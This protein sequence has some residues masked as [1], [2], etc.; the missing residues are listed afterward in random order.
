MQAWQYGLASPPPTEYNHYDVLDS[1]QSSDSDSDCSSSAT[2]A[3]AAS[4]LSTLSSAT[5]ASVWS[6][7]SSQHSDFTSYSVTGSEA[8][9]CDES[10]HA[11]QQQQ[12][13]VPG[14]L[15]GESFPPELGFQQQQTQYQAPQAPEVIPSELRKNP[16]RTSA[17]A[18]AARG[19][20]PTL[21]KQ[22]DRKVEFVDKLVGKEPVRTHPSNVLMLNPRSRFCHVYC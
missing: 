2:L 22:V 14:R 17:A 15:F 12:R 1:S 16:R 5:S 10:R 13:L 7:P 6:V 18:S 19:C 21:F 20:P 8:R 11:S 9:Y 3:S 4:S